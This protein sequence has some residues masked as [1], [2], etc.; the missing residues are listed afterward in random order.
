[1][2]ETGQLSEPIARMACAGNQLESLVR[3][4][5]SDT[6]Q[7]GTERGSKVVPK[8][9]ILAAATVTVLLTQARCGFDHELF[10]NISA[11]REFE[12]PLLI[13]LKRPA[14]ASLTE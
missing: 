2:I 3:R 6:R 12:D 13:D 1:M 14:I 10:V 11:L 7:N 8:N 9:E 4:E 5:A